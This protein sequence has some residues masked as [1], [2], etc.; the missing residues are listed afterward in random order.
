MPN[1]VYQNSIKVPRKVAVPVTREQQDR[2][3][4]YIL[5]ATIL[6]FL[7]LL[8]ILFMS[9]V[10]VG[11]GNSGSSGLSGLSGS[12]VAASVGTGTNNGSTGSDKNNSSTT[13]NDQEIDQNVEN[14]D[15]GNGDDSKTTSPNAP[16]A[17]ENNLTNNNNHN[18]E[19]TAQSPQEAITDTK[20]IEPD[21]TIT[22]DNLIDK[23]N[24]KPNTA[25]TT[26]F[27]LEQHDATLSIFGTTGKG[28]SFVFV[29]DRSGSMI[30]KPLYNAQLE[31]T[32]ALTSLTSRHRFNV[33]F[34]DN[35]K[36]IWQK[37][38][39]VS[40]TQKNKN[41]A[42]AFIRGITA[43]GGTEPL[44]PLLSAISY[45]PDVIFFL[46]DGAFNID[47]NDVCK[48]A[49]KSKINVIHFGTGSAQSLM[50]Q[51]LAER[52][53]GDYRYIDIGQLDKL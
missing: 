33:I 8:L 29:F 14:T 21:K 16:L 47:L 35:D 11:S 44:S 45:R 49:G 22:S 51:D 28:S 37:N 42:V 12:G 46:T 52:T 48:K 19:K 30:G 2:R 23:L 3:I 7:L 15:S 20:S 6:L 43:G 39:M 25:N 41:N 24:D 1:P 36:I 38:G 40:A 27:S 10:P 4:F 13:N 31:L 53:K 18:N 50:L 5:A 9:C 17:E 34:Y 26:N 32:Q